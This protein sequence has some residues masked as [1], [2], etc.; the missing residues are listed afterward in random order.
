MKG[1]MK[2]PKLLAALA[3]TLAALAAGTAPPAL[4]QVAD[5]QLVDSL[6][7]HRASIRLPSLRTSLL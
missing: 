7:S 3:V 1:F 6:E 4:A 5:D 2:L